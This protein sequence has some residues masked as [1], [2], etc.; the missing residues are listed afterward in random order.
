MKLIWQIYSVNIIIIISDLIILCVNTIYYKSICYIVHKTHPKNPYYKLKEM[1]IIFITNAII[2][3]STV[4]IKSRCTSIALA[5]VFWPSEH[6]R[7]ADLTMIF[8]IFWVEK[9]IF[10]LAFLFKFYCWVSWLCNCWNYTI[11]YCADTK[12]KI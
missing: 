11:I 6:M 3:E 7:I 5:T 12:T 10:F 9:N 8:I 1:F 4:M 2:K